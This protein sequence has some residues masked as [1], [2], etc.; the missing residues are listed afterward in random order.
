MS[1]ND[2]H[3]V[4]R[5]NVIIFAHYGALATVFPFCC[6]AEKLN[7]RGPAPPDF[8][9]PFPPHLLYLR[10]VSLA[11]ET[12]YKRIHA[13]RAPTSEAN[14]LSC[15]FL[16]LRLRPQLCGCSSRYK[17]RNEKERKR[18]PPFVLRSSSRRS[19]WKP[20]YACACMRVCVHSLVRVHLRC[21]IT[22][23]LTTGYGG[24]S[25]LHKLLVVYRTL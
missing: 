1:V 7:E 11:G 12:F 5:L 22:Y 16:Y 4:Q 8:C 2:A 9:A 21:N 15:L 24:G 18:H 14:R 19:R 13:R 25:N 3:G 17:W 23:S 20:L 10:V 6:F